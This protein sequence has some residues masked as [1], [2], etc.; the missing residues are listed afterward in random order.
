M[1]K[2]SEDGIKTN[3]T[4]ST[5]HSTGGTAP[6]SGRMK[7]APQNP[8]LPT[9]VAPKHQSSRYLTSAFNGAQ[10]YCVSG[11]ERVVMRVTAR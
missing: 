6:G 7:N 9:Q 3:T 5:R 2:S 8:Q 10:H 11:L 1:T 4:G